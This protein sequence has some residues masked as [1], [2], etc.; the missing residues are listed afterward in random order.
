MEKETKDLEKD[1]NF[2]SEE[3]VKI[4]NTINE[5]KEDKENKHE[6]DETKKEN[7]KIFI[8]RV[9]TIAIPI[10]IQ[11]ILASTLNLVDVVVIGALGEKTIAAVGIANNN[12]FF[13]LNLILFGVGSGTGVLTA[14]YWGK[15]DVPS[16]KKFL[17][18]SLTI[19]G[20]F[21]IIFTLGAMFAPSF[22]ISIFN[23]N[24]GVISF[25]S[26]YLIA[27]SLSYLPTAITFSY[28]QVLRSM[29]IVKITL[30]AS[31][32]GL[33][34]NT[35]LNY[36]LV[37]GLLGMPKFGVAGAGYATV[38]ARIIEMCIILYAVY[39]RDSHL[40]GKISELFT[41]KFSLVKKF[42]R[43]A[44]PVVLNELGWAIGTLTFAYIYGQ[45]GY[46]AVTTVNIFGT[47]ERFA[48][49]GFMGI[50]SA[51]GVIIGNTIGEGNSDKVHKYAFKFLKLA[52]ITYIVFGTIVVLCGPLILGFYDVSDGVKQD[53]TRMLY[54]FFFIF[55]FKSQNFT[56]IVGIFRSGG[57]TKFAFFADLIPLW[58]IG[59]PMAFLA[60]YLGFSVP[61]VYLMLSLE[62][63]FKFII[64]IK[65]VKS[66]KWIRSLTI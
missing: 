31:L 24:S 56:M 44:M 33:S 64:S 47:I 42:I 20:I 22:I 30:L 55:L 60:Y 52:F 28:A 8:K 53:V 11:N 41:Y 62:E 59:V 13:L 6:S 43:V 10:I 16:I 32:I 35:A 2:K 39:F 34:V 14:Q 46:K 5:N 19:T 66:N 54:L 36:I 63:F 21:A 29:G 45:I 1:S 65:R 49:V 61:M 26:T 48:W 17:G 3:D 7:N 18:I 25:G 37:Y 40:R 9:F 4:E 23:S 58:G 12:Y 50:G 27:V 15:K 51:T 38:I 57:D